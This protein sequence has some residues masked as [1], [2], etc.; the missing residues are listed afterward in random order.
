MII[1]R[2]TEVEYIQG[3]ARHYYLGTATVQFEE[4]DFHWNAPDF[5]LQ[6]WLLVLKDDFG[7]DIMEIK[8][9]L[10]LIQCLCRKVKNYKH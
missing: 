2:P 8:W 10:G 6:L 4:G 9:P 3:L 7:K 5:Y 1:S